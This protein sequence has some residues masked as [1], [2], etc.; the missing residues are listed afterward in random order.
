MEFQFFL[1][2]LGGY[3]LVQDFKDQFCN[4]YRELMLYYLD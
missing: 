2:V 1:V 3:K 4:I